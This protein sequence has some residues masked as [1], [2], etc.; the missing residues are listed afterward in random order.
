VTHQEKIFFLSFCVETEKML[1]FST[2]VLAFV[3]FHKMMY[4]HIRLDSSCYEAY[5]SFSCMIYPY[6][7]IYIYNK[8]YEI[9]GPIYSVSYMC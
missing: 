2:V 4:S 9:E 3:L 5:G 8:L 7:Y 1:L 6:P